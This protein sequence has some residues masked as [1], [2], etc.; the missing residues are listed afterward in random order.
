MKCEMRL[1]VVPNDTVV[2]SPKYTCGVN[3]GL[4]VAMGWRAPLGSW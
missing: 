2:V 3:R 1:T 4:E